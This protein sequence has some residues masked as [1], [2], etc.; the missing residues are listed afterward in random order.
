MNDKILEL[1]D[2][3]FAYRRSPEILKGI[4]LIIREGEVVV[5]LGHNGAGKTTLIRLI[6]NFT[7]GFV[8]FASLF[9]K[10]VN[11]PASRSRVGYLSESPIS[12]P[13][14]SARQFLTFF[15]RLAGLPE[16][17]LCTRV[18]QLIEKTSLHV[19]GEKR[20]GSFSKGMLQRLNLARALLNDP[21]LL[22]LD[23]P[24]FGLDPIG[25]ELIKSVVLEWKNRGK[26]VLINTHAVSFA[27]EIGDRVAFL[28]AGKIARV[29]LRNE[30]LK[31]EPPWLATICGESDQELRKLFE[32]DFLVIKTCPEFVTIQVESHEKR[33]VFNKLVAQHN[34]DLLAMDCMQNPL[35]LLFQEF[36]K[37]LSA[38][39]RAK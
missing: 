13:Q 11:D 31:P 21:D 28:M 30:S 12:Y 2:I 14:L 37:S 18:E 19:H 1:T 8:G 35:A 34:L 6:L 3:H 16:D 7:Q 39:E 29:V 17:L 25:Q 4:S 24:I 9:G 38:E 23:E 32:K 22:I 26:A 15:G 33:I 10:P 36:S 27:R 20:L 5:L